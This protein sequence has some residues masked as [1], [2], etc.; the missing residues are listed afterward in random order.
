MSRHSCWYFSFFSNSVANTYSSR[1]HPG[2]SQYKHLLFCSMYSKIKSGRRYFVAVLVRLSK[3]HLRRLA[4]FSITVPFSK[5]SLYHEVFPSIRLSCFAD[6]STNCCKYS[7]IT[8][9][10]LQPANWTAV[11]FWPP[12]KRHNMY[13]DSTA[14]LFL[15]PSLLFLSSVLELQR[16]LLLFLALCLSS[17]T[18]GGPEGSTQ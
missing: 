11:S 4:W 3:F 18:Y 7:L 17:W 12:H 16:L 2:H 10:T 6:H 8:D 14:G 13:T 9:L 15:V 5:D 1:G